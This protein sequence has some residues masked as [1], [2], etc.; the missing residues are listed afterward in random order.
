MCSFCRM[1]RDFLWTEWLCRLKRTSCWRRNWISYLPN[2]IGNF[3]CGTHW[4]VS[5]VCL[6]FSLSF[7][8][9][10]NRTKICPPTFKMLFWG[11][12]FSLGHDLLG[13]R[14]V[15]HMA[16]SAIFPVLPTRIRLFVIGCVVSKFCTFTWSPYTN[17]WICCL[18]G[19][20]YHSCGICGNCCCLTTVHWLSR[21]YS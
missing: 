15:A 2:T 3:S 19:T 17:K 20:V 13:I 10:V 14:C 9:Y 21:I 7:S 6:F 5:L 8:R 11:C 1:T 16:P 4:Q 12:V 18:H